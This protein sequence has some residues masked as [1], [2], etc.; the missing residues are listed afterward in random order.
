MRRHLSCR[1]II[2]SRVIDL[3]FADKHSLHKRPF[4]RHGSG[5]PNN[6]LMPTPSTSRTCAAELSWLVDNLRLRRPAF[7][8]RCWHKAQNSTI[9]AWSVRFTVT[10]LALDNVETVDVPVIMS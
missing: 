9:S 7:L 2:D 1:A 6:A 10:A 5:C 8:C 4:M 3:I